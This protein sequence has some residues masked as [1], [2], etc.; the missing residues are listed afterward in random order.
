MTGML[1]SVTSI[2]EAELV[3]DKCADVI[4][5]KNPHH[6]ALGALDTELVAEIVDK[7]NG[8]VLT[9]A[10]VGDMAPNDSML[11][12]NIH[13]MAATGVD[14]VKV[15]LFDS[16]PTNQFLDVISNA[17]EQ[18]IRLVIVIFAENYIADESFKPLL[19]T[20][21]NGIMLDTKNKT[22]KSLCE[23][24]TVEKLSEFVGIVK[25]NGLL[26]GLAGSL[27]YEDIN[28]LLQ[29]E[30]DY[31]GF[32]GALC[33]EN[34]RVKQLDQLKVE[35]IRNSIP[36]VNNINYDLG[37]SDSKGFKNGAVA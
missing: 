12:Q 23:I 28:Q 7:V 32:R 26:T 34:N 1:A 29:I 11:L 16:R 31:L 36:R 2:A 5:L 18:K 3:L 21:I 30:P 13:N 33:S 27:R 8:A 25:K 15:G 6:G 4:D 22:G 35:F 24:L 9:S 37:M 19:Q 14:I 20:G 10:T 17:T